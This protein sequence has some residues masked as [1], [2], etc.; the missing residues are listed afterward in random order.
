MG[1]PESA[2][3]TIGAQ[4]PS[5]SGVQGGWLAPHAAIAP[6]PAAASELFSTLE[7]AE[8]QWGQRR[9]SIRFNPPQLAHSISFAISEL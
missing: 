5:G 2:L 1:G 4:K 6:R 3:L 7:V 8:W 9:L